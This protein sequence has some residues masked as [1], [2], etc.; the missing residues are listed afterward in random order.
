MIKSNLSDDL[1][2]ITQKMMMARERN[3]V[4]KIASECNALPLQWLQY[5]SFLHRFGGGKKK[6]FSKDCA[7]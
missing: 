3:E 7:G 2:T 1:I 5:Y 6:V 4:I